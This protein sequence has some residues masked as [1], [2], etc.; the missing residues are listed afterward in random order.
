MEYFQDEVQKELLCVHILFSQIFSLVSIRLSLAFVLKDHIGTQ[1]Q[2]K[3]LSLSFSVFFF[4]SL[5]VRCRYPFSLRSNY[6]E[7]NGESKYHRI[8]KSLDLGWKGPQKS[9]SSNSSV[10]GRDILCQ[11]RLPKASFNLALNT[12][13]DGQLVPV[14]HTLIMEIFC[15][16]FNILEHTGFARLQQWIVASKRQVLALC[17]PAEEWDCLSSTCGWVLGSH[18]QDHL[19]SLWL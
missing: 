2:S 4:F 15:L 13:M 1:I 7:R 14:P 19:Y 5:R 10:R 16:I 12:S 11:A 9:L 3:C 18:K 17:I 6:L 8:I